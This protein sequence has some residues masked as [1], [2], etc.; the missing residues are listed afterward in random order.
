[1]TYRTEQTTMYNRPVI[2]GRVPHE[3]LAFGM[4]D[5]KIRVHSDLGGV[6]STHGPKGPGRIATDDDPHQA[7]RANRDAPFQARDGLTTESSKRG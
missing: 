5:R 3:K 1:M 4:P 7:R 6:R 2:N